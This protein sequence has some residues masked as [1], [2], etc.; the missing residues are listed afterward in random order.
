MLE[1]KRKDLLLVRAE[2]LER[3]EEIS[4]RIVSVV[5]ILDGSLL[6]EADPTWAGAINTVL[7]S[8][9]V[10]VSELVRISRY[11]AAPSLN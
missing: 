5:R 2:P 7:V 11:S 6:L 9:G 8:K 4:N 3:A 10:K 1:K